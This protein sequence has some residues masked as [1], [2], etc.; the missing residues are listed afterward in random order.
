MTSKKKSKNCTFTTIVMLNIMRSHT[1]LAALGKVKDIVI[2]ILTRNLI[3][4]HISMDQHVVICC[5]VS[6]N[7]LNEL[8][9]T[10]LNAIVSLLLYAVETF[11]ELQIVVL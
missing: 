3:G 11:I 9:E 2:P 7:W 6:A 10:D 4:D 5:D 8:D 1:Y